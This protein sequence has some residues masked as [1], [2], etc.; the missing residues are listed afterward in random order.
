MDNFSLYTG[1]RT[2]EK[3][4]NDL[5]VRLKVIHSDENFGTIYGI[6]GPEKAFIFVKIRRMYSKVAVQ[7]RFKLA[8]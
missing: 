6:C 1:R 2:K 3:T 7:L 8:P 5:T 4:I